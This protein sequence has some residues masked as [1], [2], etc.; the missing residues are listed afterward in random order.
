V[1]RGTSIISPAVLEAGV[2]LLRKLMEFSM[3]ETGGCFLYTN[4]IL[5]IL[6]QGNTLYDLQDIKVLVD[7]VL[8]EL[9]DLGEGDKVTHVW[10]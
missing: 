3:Q 6:I 5:F 7:V 9:A 1:N 8:R 2:N 4:G 10:E